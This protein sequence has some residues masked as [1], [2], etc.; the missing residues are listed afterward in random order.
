MCKRVGTKFEIWTKNVLKNAH[1]VLIFIFIS[2]ISNMG[3]LD[4]PVHL[5]PMFCFISKISVFCSG[6][7]KILKSIKRKGKTDK[8]SLREKCPRYGVFYDPYFPVFGLDT[9]IYSVI[10]RIQ[11]K[12][13]KIQARK[14]SVFWHFSQMG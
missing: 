9:E 14:K 10:L 11:S 12:Y 2:K 7:C 6:Y 3:D 13:G 5:V 4:T 1:F 8:E